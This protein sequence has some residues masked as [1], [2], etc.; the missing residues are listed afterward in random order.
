M[1]HRGHACRH[2]TDPAEHYCH[3]P[4]SPVS[5]RSPTFG[6]IAP[7]EWSVP[8]R[9]SGF[10]VPLGTATPNGR[11]NRSPRKTRPHLPGES[12]GVGTPHLP[13]AYGERRTESPTCSRTG[14]NRTATNEG[15]HAV[16]R[17]AC[18]P[19]RREEKAAA[20]TKKRRQPVREKDRKQQTGTA[21]PEAGSFPLKCRTKARPCSRAVPRIFC[22]IRHTV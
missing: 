1:P 22:A 21:A 6:S 7:T 11:G 2:S 14:G 3:I 9:S 10:T 8:A 12:Q 15:N 19:A 13:S 20:R 17:A 18:S 4:A 5:K 16:A